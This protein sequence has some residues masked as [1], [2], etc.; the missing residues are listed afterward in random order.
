MEN[1]D[2]TPD[3]LQAELVRYD[4][5]VGDSFVDENGREWVTLTLAAERTGEERRNI[6]FW[7]NP[8]KGEASK[9]P[10]QRVGEG[11]RAPWYVDIEAVEEFIPIA[12]QKRKRKSRDNLPTPTTSE[13]A[14]AIERAGFVEGLNQALEA[15]VSE[16]QKEKA[17]LE[18]QLNEIRFT[19]EDRFAEQIKEIEQ[20]LSGRIEEIQKQDESV[21]LQAENDRLRAE[22]EELRKVKEDLPVIDLTEPE[23]PKRRF[24][25]LRG[26]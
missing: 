18:S 12:A 5:Q 22:I 7:A 16:L 9:I 13:F 17:A 11:G 10:A 26:S 23:T 1:L 15:R 8:G 21:R 4:K 25:W 2:N 14:S 24:A 3:S 6:E 20:R 19:K